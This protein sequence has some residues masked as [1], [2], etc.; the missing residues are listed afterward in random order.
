MKRFHISLGLA[1]GMGGGT[2][3]LHLTKHYTGTTH[4]KEPSGM[5]KEG[6]HHC[7]R[8]PPAPD[9]NGSFKRAG[10]GLKRRLYF[11][12]H[13]YAEHRNAQWKV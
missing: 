8:T 1:V 5:P 11:T 4:R 2:P 7:C 6:S 3:A 9:T 13:A 12:Q 10:T